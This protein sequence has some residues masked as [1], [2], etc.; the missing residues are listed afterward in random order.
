MEDIKSWDRWS[1]EAYTKYTRL[2]DVQKK[3]LFVMI[4]DVIN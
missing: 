2:V 3:K 4:S 1:G